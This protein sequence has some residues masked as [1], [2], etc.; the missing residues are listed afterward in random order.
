LV[1]LEADDARLR[2]KVRIRTGKNLD[3]VRT[4]VIPAHAVGTSIFAIAALPQ[5][6][7]DF[8]RGAGVADHDRLRGRI[9][10]RRFWE[11][12]A[13]QLF[14]RDTGIFKVEVREDAAH[15]QHDCQSDEDSG[16][17]EWF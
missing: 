6:Q 14:V 9:E 7:R 13:D 12:T 17:S 11:R 16:L 1:A 15:D 3:S 8:R 4:E 10:Q 2:L 5:T